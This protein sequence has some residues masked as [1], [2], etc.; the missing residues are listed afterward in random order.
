M[1]NDSG[2]ASRD[3]SGFTGLLD[4]R[5]SD[6]LYL[7]ASFGQDHTDR[8]TGKKPL[9]SFFGVNFGLSKKPVVQ[10]AK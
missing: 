9:V 5:I 2:N 4:Y 8:Q 6:D 7:T 1:T 3:S 10:V